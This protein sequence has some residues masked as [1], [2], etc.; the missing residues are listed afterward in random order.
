[1]SSYR[2]RFV[3][4]TELPKGLS[5]FDA[6]H[7]FGLSSADV[8]RIRK[9]PVKARL[10]A[11]AQLVLVR[12]TGRSFAHTKTLPPSLLQYLSQTL[13]V[14]DLTIAS[15]RA[16]YS[17]QRTLF[18]HRKWAFEEA[19]FRVSEAADIEA[20]LTSLR[21]QAGNAI[22]IDDL[23]RAGELWLFDRKIQ[24]PSDRVIRDVAR[25]A[26]A[27][28]GL[29]A[30]DVV[31]LH[32]PPA[33]LDQV[34]KIVFA[35]R[36]GRKSATV[37][38]WLKVPTGK[39]SPSNLS[40]VI[41]KIQFLKEL[42]V[43]EWTLEGIPLRRMQSFGQNVVNRPP[44]QTQR[45]AR[46]TQHLEIVCFLRMTLL[47]LTDIALF[48]SGRR[49]G[50]LVNKA[51]ATVSRRKLQSVGEFRN[52]EIQA[53]SLLY[54]LKL[55]AE[56]KVAELQALFPD[57]KASKNFSHAA[58][59]RQA[60]SEDHVRVKTLISDMMA[61][62]F[63]GS[64]GLSAMKQIS[65]LRDL[66]AKNANELPKD[67]DAGMVDPTWR[68]IV[69]GPD[70]KQGLTG[71]RACALMSVRK[72]LKGGRIWIDHS[73]DFRSRDEMLITKD[74]WKSKRSLLVGSLNMPLDP[75]R[76]LEP[77]LATLAVGMKAMAEA[78]EA[79]KV[80]INDAGHII[81]APIEALEVDENVTRTRDQIFKVIGKVQLSD[82]IVDVD[83]A[84]NFSE[85]L[86]GHKAD[87]VN[88]LLAVYG[89]LLA[90]G[91]EVS[92]KVVSAMIPG[93]EVPQITS[94]MRALE[95][96]GRLS[97]ANERVLRYQLQFPVTQL[98]SAGDKGSSDMMSLDATQH[99]YSARIDPRRRTHAVGIYTHV[100]GSYGIFH[101]EAIVLNTRQQ[102]IAVH[103]VETYNATR[104]SDEMRLSLLA[105]DTHGYTNVAMSVAKGLGFDLCPRLKNLA[106][107]KLFV[108]R[109]FD[110]PQVLER[111]TAA[112]V[113][114]KPI[115]AGWDDFLRMLASIKT[116]RV[117]PKFLLEKLG[118]AAQG[119][120]LHKCLDSLGRLLRTAYLCDYYTN[121]EFRR[122]IH[123]L[124]NRGES[125]HQLQ[126]AVYSGRLEPERGRRDSEM[127]A[128]SGSHALL[129]NVLLAWNTAQIQLVADKWKKEKHAIEDVWLR[130]LGPAHFG[131]VNFRGM[132]TFGV[133]KYLDALLRG[134]EP[135]PRR[136]QR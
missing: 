18:E 50:N 93:I 22:S 67:F 59:V 37:V 30:L 23:V 17:R 54:D 62:D 11:A 85:A 99:L 113:S 9:F 36:L 111:A 81:I 65:A 104:E 119:D 92:A 125:V 83:V 122:E 118:S 116:G 69:S 24:L 48:M 130:R 38:E 109:G 102:S 49:I 64:E 108:P 1:M 28:A 87:S 76:F 14:A 86:L 110:V 56:K 134:H 43:N 40:E 61:L 10:A 124:L 12:A 70:R 26:F 3:G 95:A 84:C 13:G 131:H 34:L 35:K 73:E 51:S 20:M 72:S 44:A 129:S 58:Q 97:K 115:A 31:R 126:R 52:R 42:G 132:L 80:E 41:A 121:P 101:D 21:A 112:E 74:E 29:C 46:E 89:A 107:Q 32:L 98:W 88:E 5:E 39:H 60:M 77:L 79:G 57:D 136:A 75:V 6:E 120:A 4:L 2:Q 117:S 8:E 78:Q 68:D 103:G 55:S 16:L 91:T 66:H 45:L 123:T 33:K 53:R 27:G 71:L 135:V 63:Q 47:E 90:H 100:L 106:E 94:A 96:H 25:D 15:L 82:V 19:G 105:V 127:R 133:E 7:A 128:I 114:L